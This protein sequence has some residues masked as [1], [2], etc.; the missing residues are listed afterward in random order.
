MVFRSFM[1]HS[2]EGYPLNLAKCLVEGKARR[3]ELTQLTNVGRR[4]RKL[5]TWVGLER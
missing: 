3:D 4:I 2:R 5:A 1:S